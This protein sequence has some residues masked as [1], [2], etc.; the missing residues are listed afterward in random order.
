MNKYL[1]EYIN[2]V[3]G[4]GDEGSAL[5][6]KLTASTLNNCKYV[7]VIK[8]GMNGIAVLR[9]LPKDH[10][11]VV[12]S[13]SGDTEISDIKGYSRSMVDKLVNLSKK[14]NFTPLAFADV[15]DAS[16]GNKD[17]IQI[18]G[19]ELRSAADFYG[20]SILNGELAILGDRVNGIANING[21]MIAIRPKSNISSF[22]PFMLNDDGTG[23]RAASF[24]HEGKPV[25]INSDGIGTKTEFYERKK[26]GM[27]F[28]LG[29][30]LAM[31]LDDTIKLGATAKVVSDVVEWRKI[32]SGSPPSYSMDAFIEYAEKFSEANNIQYILKFENSED[33][34]RG[35]NPDAPSFNVSGSVVSIID[36]ERLR[37]P[38]TPREGDYLVSISRHHNPRSNGITDK[39]K[40]MV[41]LFGENYQ[42]TADG[43]IFLRYLAAPS[44]VLYPYFK[45]LL[46]NNLITSVYHMSGGAYNGKLARPLA[47]HGLFVEMDHLSPPDWRE[48]KLAEASSTPVESAYAKWPMGNDGFVTVP[49]ENIGK[50]I[51]YLS[52]MRMKWAITGQLQRHPDKTGVELMAYNGQKIY[53][54]GK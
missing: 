8:G 49:K 36:E 44:L 54:S 5:L 43:K 38:P 23:V 42:D 29:D 15:I 4:K 6:A 7:D 12:Y 11:V 22:T 53:F 14:H 31:K 16:V 27:E 41:K 20:L 2:E 50:V 9:N 25:Y 26:R 45:H 33:R 32:F 19:Q 1:D 3:I 17:D 10:D 34:I 46:D 51:A 24:D 18:I 13:V 30:S 40:L 52:E 35:Y 48:L 28:C 47:K 21:T 39:R 37:N